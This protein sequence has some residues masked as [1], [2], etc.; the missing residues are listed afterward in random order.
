VEESL[1]RALLLLT[2][3]AC[4]KNPCEEAAAGYTARME[5]CGLEGITAEEKIDCDENLES[6]YICL[7]DCATAA[8]CEALDGTSADGSSTY[9]E[10]ITACGTPDV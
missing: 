3:I 4:S 1:M 10:C 8:S 9:Q 2:L 7:E 5:E 6:Y